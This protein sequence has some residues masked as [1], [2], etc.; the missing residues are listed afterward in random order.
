M[1]A[2]RRSEVS[3]SS[4]ARQSP[5]RIAAKGAFVVV[6]DTGC[7]DTASVGSWPNVELSRHAGLARE[8]SLEITAAD[9]VAA[10]VRTG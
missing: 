10:D 7:A 6:V 1:A 9:Q 5:F 8:H 4:F 3:A 2:L